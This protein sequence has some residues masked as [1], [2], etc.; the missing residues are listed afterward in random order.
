MNTT[1]NNENDD[2]SDDYYAKGKL[3]TLHDYQDKSKIDYK[4]GEY[5]TFKND[6]TG[7][8]E[9]HIPMVENNEEMNTTTNREIQHK[10]DMP[11]KNFKGRECNLIIKPESVDGRWS[12]PGLSKNVS[13]IMD[14]DPN[15]GD[16]YAFINKGRNTV[17][18]LANINQDGSMVDVKL[19]YP[20]QIEYWPDKKTDKKDEVVVSTGQ[21]RNN[22]LMQLYFFEN[23]F[24]MLFSEPVSN[25][26]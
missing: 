9:N 10:T 15:N 2:F 7:P 26:E 20:N 1:T 16:I 8:D 23:I 17:R 14:R 18:L 19:Q 11:D 25:S 3:H 22:F 5:T 24:N 6:L 13:V 12:V 21:E 4:D